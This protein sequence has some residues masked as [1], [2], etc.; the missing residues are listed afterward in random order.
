MKMKSLIAV[1]VSGVLAV[2]L[3]YA[4]PS[5][6]ADAMDSLGS[7]DDAPMQLADN[8]LSG[9]STMSGSASMSGTSSMSGNGS[10]NTGSSSSDNGSADTA[11][12]DEDY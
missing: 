7:M 12:G 1:A 11:T 9:A 5:N 4:A 10:A 3:S 2:S 8:G 6:N